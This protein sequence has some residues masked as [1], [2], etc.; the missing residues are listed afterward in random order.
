M[1]QFQPHEV[2][3]QARSDDRAFY[4]DVALAHLTT[5]EF[6]NNHRESGA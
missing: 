6:M 2:F 3:L 1:R 5:K 4:E